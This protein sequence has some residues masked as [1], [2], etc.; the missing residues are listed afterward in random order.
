MLKIE[1]DHAATPRHFRRTVGYFRWP[2]P[3][4]TPAAAKTGKLTI[5][6]F[7]M[8]LVLIR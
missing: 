8:G 4:P 3:R 2:P 1:S 7:A 6:A 5:S